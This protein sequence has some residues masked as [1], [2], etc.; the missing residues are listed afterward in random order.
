[1][2]NILY[3]GDSSAS[4]TSA[5]RADAIKRLGHTVVVIDPYNAFSKQLNSRW[6]GPIHF[7]TGYALLQTK[8]AK[9]LTHTL[10]NTH[11]KPDLIWVDSGE[12]FG[13]ECVKVLKKITCPVVLYNIDDPTGKRDGKRFDSLIQ[14]IPF[15]DLIAV[16]RRET[17]KECRQLGAKNVIRVYRSYDEIAHKPF[18]S[19]SEI[20]E[21]FKSEVAFIGTWMRYEKRDEFLLELISSGIPVSIWGDRWQKSPHFAKLESHWK[22]PALGGRDYV[23][24]VQGAKI[25]LGLLS[26]GNRDL[27]TTRSLEVP[28]SG[29]LLC[30]QRT[31]EHQE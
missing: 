1:M 26:K 5:H 21:K 4:S 11:I 20:P 9:W 2:A 22:G 7:R 28:Y 10:E 25:C 13:P 16:V 8:V 3:V 31:I 29:G 12:L 15:Y 18:N 6:F 17:E 23:A 24:A 30:A 14:S 27:H 19:I